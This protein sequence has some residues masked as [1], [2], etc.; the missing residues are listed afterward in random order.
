MKR[1]IATTILL[2]L[3]L[4]CALA[5]GTDFLWTDVSGSQTLYLS[6]YNG[7]DRSVSVPTSAN[8]KTVV[9]IGREAFLGN[10]AT[11][12]VLPYTVTYI[13]D[14][15]FAD[16]SL[17]Q[18]IYLTGPI[19]ELG[20]GVFQYCTSLEAIVLPTNL[21][22]VP[23]S[24]F[25]GCTRL[26]QISI[27]L[28]VTTIGESA[29]AQCTSLTAL[30]LPSSVTTIAS[31]A[32]A[33]CSSLQ[34]IVLPPTLETLSP[35]AFSGCTSLT[36]LVERGSQAET[37]CRQRGLSYVNTDTQQAQR[38]RAQSTST[39]ARI[40]TVPIAVTTPVPTQAPQ[41]VWVTAMPD[42]YGYTTF[43]PY[44]IPLT[45]PDETAVPEPTWVQNKTGWRYKYW[46]GSYAKNKWLKID[47]VWYHFDAKGYMETNAWVGE[48]FVGP[49]GHKVT[50]AWVDGYY[51]GPDGNWDHSV[52]AEGAHVIGRW[53]KDDKGWWY[54]YSNGTYPQNQ[55]LELEG[56]YYYLGSDGYMVRGVWV[57]NCYLK[58]NGEMAR[59]AWKGDSY[60]GADG[61]LVPGKVKES[62]AEQAGAWQQD[63]K[64]WW[65]QFADGSYPASRWCEIDGKWYHFDSK[66]YMQKNQWIDNYYVTDSG[67]MVVD[68]WIKDAYVDLDGRWIEDPNPAT[69]A[70]LPIIE[71]ATN[72][73]VSEWQSLY[74]PFMQGGYR[75][76][77]QAFAGISLTAPG[78]VASDTVAFSLYDINRDGVPE[79]LAYA[80]S[81]AGASP[82]APSSSIPASLACTY[83]Y[84]ISNHA[85]QLVG[86][87][88]STLSALCWYTSDSYPGLFQVGSW[89]S[90]TDYD[91]L[92]HAL[93]DGIT[94]TR[95]QV[96]QNTALV[97][98]AQ[99]TALRHPLLSLS[100]ETAALMD[101]S[102][103]SAF[104]SAQ[105][106][107]SVQP[108]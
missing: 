103:I 71:P 69:W 39:P 20:S 43:A 54:S 37:L 24:L 104:F 98:L 70:R 92:Y 93:P 100:A 99:S 88:D 34:Y 60:V 32:F 52:V 23:D 33:G 102:G 80:G 66:G 97:A 28:T 2:L 86:R 73:I 107:S 47:D 77:S 4:G 53:K 35:Q 89:N 40:T 84:T 106:L 17:L 21:R 11:T 65:Y 95:T 3:C 13:G 90:P 105:W 74:L 48:S 87:I 27:P 59:N 22:A 18:S 29:F 83:V 44:S 41:N 85:M 67:E 42:T 6:R 108:K 96:V 75:T 82:N 38:I 26:S 25:M 55:W 12:V 68:A 50:N 57:D 19:T 101:A 15:A 46:D 30:E 8:G 14:R 36:L 79:L 76:S 31:H 58:M 94:L 1:V 7:Y 72:V 9:G 51:I 64:G 5:D 62:T 78:S 49:D 81:T 10:G 61:R 45:A 16:M 63:S 91:A 56:R